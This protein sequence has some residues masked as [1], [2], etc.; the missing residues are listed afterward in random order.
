MFFQKLGLV[1][2]PI[3]G[4]LTSCKKSEIELM[5]CIGDLVLR[6]DKW[7]N[8]H[9]NTEHFK[10]LHVKMNISPPL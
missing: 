9:T 3:Y 1:V 7:T 4:F 2:F 5:S 8:R 6:S 10:K